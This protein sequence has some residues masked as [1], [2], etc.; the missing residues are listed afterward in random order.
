MGPAI[1][2]NHI[3]CMAHVIQLCLGAFMA[4]LGVKGQE[5]SWEAHQRDKHFDENTTSKSNESKRSDFV[6]ARICYVFLTSSH[7][8]NVR[9]YQ[10][11]DSST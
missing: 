10:R 11:I 1:S 8:Q 2:K 5:K 9:E 3:P 4:S 6:D 7:H